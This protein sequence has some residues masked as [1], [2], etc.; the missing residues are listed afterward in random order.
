M[1]IQL[2]K[3]AL[4]AESARCMKPADRNPAVIEAPVSVPA[5]S[6]AQEPMR[7]VFWVIL[8]KIH[9]H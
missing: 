1:I 6:G 5:A 9:H 4:Q 3:S 2:I 7:P 8:R